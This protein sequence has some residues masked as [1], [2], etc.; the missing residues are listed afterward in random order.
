MSTPVF[1]P[2][3]GAPNFDKVAVFYVSRHPAPDRQPVTVGL[4][5]VYIRA[6]ISWSLEVGQ[7]LDEAAPRED[8]TVMNSHEVPRR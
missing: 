5:T 7:A 8:E 3:T 4:A 2:G 1:S 6:E